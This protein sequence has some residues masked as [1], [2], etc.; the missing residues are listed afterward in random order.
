MKRSLTILL[1]SIGALLLVNFFYGQAHRVSISHDIEALSEKCRVI[2][3]LKLDDPS[4]RIRFDS[5]IS[6]GVYHFLL[7]ADQN[8]PMYIEVG[9][10][11]ILTEFLCF[12]KIGCL[13]PMYI[14]NRC[15]RG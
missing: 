11:G 1:F 7:S 4:S 2:S 14:S 10:R 8:N 5:D 12:P 6:G 3:S 15:N 9:G 13:M